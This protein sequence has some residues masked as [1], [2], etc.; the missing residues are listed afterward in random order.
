V[1]P[2]RALGNPVPA[3]VPLMTCGPMAIRE[4]ATSASFRNLSLAAA[5]TSHERQ[6]TATSRRQRA[7]TAAPCLIKPQ[8]APPF[9]GRD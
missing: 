1:V 5:M 8:G 9:G 2:G 7:C 3:H 4:K 6:Q